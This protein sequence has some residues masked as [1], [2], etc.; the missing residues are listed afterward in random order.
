MGRREDAVWQDGLL[1]EKVEEKVCKY[2]NS[3]HPEYQ[4]V[5][6]Q[7]RELL[8]QHP[9]INEVLDWNRAVELTA[10]EHEALNKLLQLENKKSLIEREYYFYTGQSMLFSYRGMLARLKRALEDSDRDKSG[11][12][13]T[14]V[15]DGSETG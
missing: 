8:V 3:K 1:D 15:V 10:Q 4:G 14:G 9:K 11:G 6:R 7:I 13:G 12:S 5:K 2:L